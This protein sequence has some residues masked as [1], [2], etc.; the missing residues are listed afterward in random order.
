M[1]NKKVVN[2]IQRLQKA[3]PQIVPGTMRHVDQLVNEIY[4]TPAAPRDSPDYFENLDRHSYLTADGFI[5]FMDGKTPMLAITRE[6]DNL[7]LRHLKDSWTQIKR[8][9]EYRPSLREIDLALESPDT[10]IINLRNLRLQ[11]DYLKSGMEHAYLSFSTLEYDRLNPE[12]RKLAQRIYG[13]KDKFAANMQMVYNQGIDEERIFVLSPDYVQVNAPLV[14]VGRLGNLRHENYYFQATDNSGAYTTD[15]NAVRGTPRNDLSNQIKIEAHK[16]MDYITETKTYQRMKELL[17]K[18][19]E[20]ISLPAPIRYAMI[21]VPVA[22][23]LATGEVCAGQL[24]E[25]VYHKP[26]LTVQIERCVEQEL[27]NRFHNDFKFLDTE[28]FG[29]ED[30]LAEAKAAYI[31]GKVPQ[32]PAYVPKTLLEGLAYG[33]AQ[34]QQQGKNYC[35]EKLSE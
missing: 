9:K 7:L 35:I 8:R 22:F 13:P 12:E 26:P 20:F 21:G 11:D 10:Q 31:E 6:A 29:S 15:W 4:T 2:I 34:R 17:T 28:V 19:D 3:Y 24:D 25:V 30:F 1:K 18:E 16:M 14:K 5:Y 33:A 32:Q 23:V 27:E